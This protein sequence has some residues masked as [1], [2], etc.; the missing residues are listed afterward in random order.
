MDK[1]NI[2][3]FIRVIKNDITNRDNAYFPNK[4]VKKPIYNSIIYPN[5]MFYL[6]VEINVNNK[7][8]GDSFT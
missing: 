1:D 2:C 6:G 4:D 3:F 5:N 7:K 8:Y